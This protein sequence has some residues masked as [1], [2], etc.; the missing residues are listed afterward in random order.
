MATARA[1]TKKELLV[2]CVDHKIPDCSSSDTKE[3]LRKRVSKY[4]SEQAKLF[5]RKSCEGRKS[6]T[7]WGRD[8]LLEICDRIEL[9][10]PKSA[11]KEDLCSAIAAF[12]R[13]D[14][15]LPPA[16]GVKGEKLTV[17]ELRELCKKN[18]VK[19][20][21]GYKKDELIKKCWA[22]RKQSIEQEKK[23]SVGEKEPLQGTLA[24]NAA[25]IASS[26]SGM[27]WLIRKYRDRA[28]IPIRPASLRSTEFGLDFCDFSLCWHVDM[29]YLAWTFVMHEEYFWS[30]VN[31]WCDT[32]FVVVPVYLHATKGGKTY[33]HY[34]YTVI[35]RE[36]KTMERFEPY[37]T[38]LVYEVEKV[39]K[40]ARLDSKLAD[41]AKKHGYEYIPPT[42]F[43]PRIGLQRREELE[44]HAK[45]P[46]D[47][48]GFCSYWSLWYAD[49]R[50]RYP[51]LSP[52]ELLTKLS[53]SLEGENRSLKNFIR[54]FAGFIENEK[55]RIATRARQYQTTKHWTMARALTESLLWEVL[56]ARQIGG[57]GGGNFQLLEMTREFEDGWVDYSTDTC[58]SVDQGELSWKGI[59]G[60]GDFGAVFLL[61]GKK[62]VKLIPLETPIPHPEQCNPLD[63]RDRRR[64]CVS[65]SVEE[66]WQ[67]VER[68]K[69]AGEMGI[70]PKVYAAKVCEGKLTVNSSA[71]EEADEEDDEDEEE[72]IGF[73]KEQS[74]ELGMIV[75][76]HVGQTL[77]EFLEDDE[78]EDEEAWMEEAE[79]LASKLPFSHGDLH[80]GNVMLK[81]DKNGDYIEGSMRLIDFA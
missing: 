2:F 48:L 11:S 60:E 78:E 10:C 9:D 31:E 36:R 34:N 4:F 38:D 37:G 26:L 45:R 33:R 52:K 6:D 75:M 51:N 69:I 25:E 35:D 12:F 73:E 42:S 79:E 16:G 40:E 56:N 18:N 30:V 59:I 23:L 13:S 74:V 80:P 20:F 24:E 65:V 3:E 19:G 29:D 64:T 22:E 55:R 43:C 71:Y 76:E 81:T 47:P 1:S 57:G 39:F 77:K 5:K 61:K 46:N 58:L 21:S 8:E 54:D 7:S 53:E 62:V 17:K 14:R 28:C 41:S 63:E 44:Q 27:L 70:G 32:R 50:L 49:R 67:E 68:A 72:E 66:F 15:D